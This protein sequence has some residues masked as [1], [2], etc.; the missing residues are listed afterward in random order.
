[1]EGKNIAVTGNPI[2]DEIKQGPTTGGRELL[3]IPDEVPVILILGGSQGAAIINDLIVKS[4]IRLIEDFYVIHQA[5][6]NN[7]DLVRA[8]TDIILNNN[9]N[10]ERYILYPTLS[11]EALSM[12][13][14][15]AD[16]IITRAGSSLFEIATWGVPA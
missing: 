10:K 12:A 13:G 5:G 4:L 9:P 14:H 6:P 7:F 1:F 11:S 8:E 15:A 2:R 16:L 3:G